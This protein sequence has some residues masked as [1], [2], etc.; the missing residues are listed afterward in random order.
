MAALQSPSPFARL[1]QKCKVLELDEKS[2]PGPALDASVPQYELALN[3]GRVSL[4]YLIRQKRLK[5]LRV[6]IHHDGM[7]DIHYDCPIA[8]TTAHP[9][10]PSIGLESPPTH[11]D[12]KPLAWMESKIDSCVAHNHTRAQRNFVPDR[13]IRVGQDKLSLI[14]TKDSFN[15]QFHQS[16]ATELP[17]YAALTYCWGPPPHSD[18]QLKTKQANLS[19]HLKEIP[20]DKLPQAIKDAVLVT[21]ALS[22]PYLWIDALC[23]LQDVD[24]DWA[25]Q[26]TQIDNIYGNSHVTI[27]AAVSKNCE[28]GFITR[29]DMMTVPFHLRDVT[30]PPMPIAIYFPSYHNTT[31][32]DIG[33]VAWVN[34]GWT[35][36]ERMASTRM[37]MF[38][39]S[40]VHFQC[41]NDGF[42]M[43]KYQLEY[44]FKMVNRDL[45][46]E[47]DVALIY[48]EW[49]TEIS[50]GFSFYRL[51]FTRGTDILPS[52]AGLATLFSH[53]LR[54]DYVAGL[55][56]KDLYRCLKWDLDRSDSLMGY[57]DLLDGLQHP[58]P[59]IAP[60]W[61]WASR[62][63]LVMFSVYRNGYI[64]NT[65]SECAVLEAVV[66]LKS[67]S[68]FGELTGGYLDI[69]AKLYTGSRQLVYQEMDG[70]GIP[71]Q[72]LH[73]GD[74]YLVDIETDCILGEL[75]E[76]RDGKSELSVPISFLLIGSTIEE[77]RNQGKEVKTSLK[78]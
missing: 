62:S 11:L 13:L 68:T 6:N 47:G 40:N 26:C 74:Q 24:S 32:E 70:E 12:P 57:K 58:A 42:S 64:T 33:A 60:S 30:V 27:S 8:S 25:Y 61:S 53:R 41:R 65:R 51:E 72:T 78:V 75:F 38:G 67:T 37:L 71:R 15:S 39:K 35:F 19:D 5:A 52:I 20:E 22:I 36:Q 16:P 49:A 55:W 45:L 18:R 29:K 4:C 23:I 77:E 28:E 44:H 56:K 10:G 2:L 9:Q 76:E 1:C 46:N 73:L 69:S 14:L 31:A 63:G 66:Q 48:E 3:W 54:D 59:Y 43:S 34:R 17:Y 50:E 7:E 21:R